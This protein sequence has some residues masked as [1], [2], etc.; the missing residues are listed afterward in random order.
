MSDR[1]SPH[2]GPPPEYRGREKGGPPCWC[3]RRP[4]MRP[5]SH[6]DRRDGQQEDLQVVPEGSAAVVLH[7]HAHP[8]VEA[9]GGAA[10][11]LPD[12][13]EAGGDLQAAAMPRLAG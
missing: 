12:A 7:V 8:V 3:Y 11:D 2:P 6:D 5:P 13:G 9:D 4:S 1:D 10:F